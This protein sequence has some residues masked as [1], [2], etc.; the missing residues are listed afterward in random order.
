MNEKKEYSLNEVAELLEVRPET[1]RIFLEQGILLTAV[2]KTEPAKD[3]IWG[4][5]VD[6]VLTQKDIDIVRESLARRAR[7]KILFETGR[8]D[9]VLKGR[10][11]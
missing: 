10:L 1:V 7:E 11:H 2:P 9:E 4:R 6:W 8:W 3:D 5:N